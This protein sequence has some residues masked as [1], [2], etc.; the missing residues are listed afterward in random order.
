MPR[1][2]LPLSVAFAATL[3]TTISAQSQPTGFP[4]FDTLI[5]E[6]RF[7]ADDREWIQRAAQAHRTEL[8]LAALAADRARDVRVRQLAPRLLRDHEIELG[9]LQRIAAE[10]GVEIPEITDIQQEMLD[11]LRS[12]DG[13]LFDR[14]FVQQVINEH[15]DQHGIYR[16]I[17]ENP[18]LALRVYGERRIPSIRQHLDRARAIGY[19]SPLFNRWWIAGSK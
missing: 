6:P 7:T 16:D 3:V 19:P 9:Q 13:Y 2:L 10:K 1:L 5:I 17:S 14:S 12:L 18:N 11:R 4:R 8:L 15:F